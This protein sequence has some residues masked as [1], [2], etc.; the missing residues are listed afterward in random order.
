MQAL[1]FGESMKKFF[2]IIALIGFMGISTYLLLNE[3]KVKRTA[4]KPISTSKRIGEKTRADFPAYELQRQ[5]I[6]ET[7]V[8]KFESKNKEDNY[9]L[10]E[11]QLN[12]FAHSMNS[13]KEVKNAGQ[14]DFEQPSD[15]NVN[16][17]ES[18]YIFDRD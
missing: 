6:E 16:K 13:L 10:D 11:D 4:L 1:F 9:E 15:I 12:E 3:R 5:R 7:T 17:N 18:Y 2:T 8:Y 14:L